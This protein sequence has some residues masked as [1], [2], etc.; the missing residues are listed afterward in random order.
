[1]NRGTIH[2]SVWQMFKEQMC[3]TRALDH[4]LL[5][6]TANATGLDNVISA[7]VTYSYVD[8]ISTN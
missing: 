3:F 7:F 4:I 8:F 6:Q 1:M 5:C 2:L